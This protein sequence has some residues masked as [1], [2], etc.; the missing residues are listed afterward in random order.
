VRFLL[1][2][3]ANL[4]SYSYGG[5]TAAAERGY[6]R[7]IQAFLEEGADINARVNIKSPNLGTRETLTLLEAAVAVCQNDMVRFLLNK[8]AYISAP[9][10]ER[11][12][13]YG[14]D[15]T[16]KMGRLGSA[17]SRWLWKMALPAR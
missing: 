8:G 16:D 10:G 12:V 9:Q 17:R 15:R 2:N 14:I 1:A 4:T 11:T 5:V 6:Q 3:G 7:V 13:G